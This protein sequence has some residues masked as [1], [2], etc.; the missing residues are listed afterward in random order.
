MSA[1]CGLKPNEVLELNLGQV[2]A[3]IDGYSYRLADEECNAIMAGYYS[4][5]YQSKHPRKPTEI[6][7]KL[8]QA[9]RDKVSGKRKSADY[10][11]DMVD[12]IARF[13]EMERRFASAN[14]TGNK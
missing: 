3:V 1:R 11:V 9:A 10:K 14:N 13:E 4:A 7:K 6:I 8:M 5:Y 2:Q 12:E